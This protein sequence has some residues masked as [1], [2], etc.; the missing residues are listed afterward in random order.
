VAQ[1]FQEEVMIQSVFNQRKI[2]TRGQKN[3]D[4][5]GLLPTMEARQHESSN[6]L[7]SNTPAFD[8]LF[9]GPVASLR[10]IPVRSNG[11]SPAATA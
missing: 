1:W 7:Q 10:E 5:A 2:F 4:S 8:T 11:P 3:L 6:D 9:F